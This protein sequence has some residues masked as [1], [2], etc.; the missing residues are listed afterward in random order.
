[1]L[2]SA[3]FFFMLVNASEPRGAIKVGLQRLQAA[4]PA[5]SPTESRTPEGNLTLETAGDFFSAADGGFQFI[6]NITMISVVVN[7]LM[8]MLLLVALREKKS[9]ADAV[10]QDISSVL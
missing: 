2:Q 7:I 10:K 6:T 8:F 3:F 1:M 4:H 5:E 9:H